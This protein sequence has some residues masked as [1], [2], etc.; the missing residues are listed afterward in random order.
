MD[1]NKKY[2]IRFINQ[3]QRHKHYEK[4]AIVQKEAFPHK[5]E[6]EEE[7]EIKASEDCLNYTFFS[8]SKDK[9]HNDNKNYNFGFIRLFRKDKSM[10]STFIVTSNSEE[11]NRIITYFVPTSTIIPEF[12]FFTYLDEGVRRAVI[13]FDSFQI[14]L[15]GKN[16]NDPNQANL[17][18]IA[19]WTTVL[20]DEFYLNR[21]FTGSSNIL[22]KIIFFLKKRSKSL[23]HQSYDDFNSS[24]NNLLIKYFSRK[25]DINL[26]KNYQDKL[27]GELKKRIENCH[28]QI[29]YLSDKSNSIESS[30]VLL[31]FNLVYYQWIWS[32]ILR[33]DQLNL[34]T[35]ES[36]KI[37]NLNLRYSELFKTLKP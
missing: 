14:L 22:D 11:S 15:I 12:I 8:I 18:E 27:K 31:I 35:I 1:L 21:T 36:N 32:A 10:I 2:I 26:L 24:I 30:I 19:E 20:D 37:Q 5:I 4:H 3:D 28:F 9:F 13:N 33:F 6:N 34:K 7:Y 17:E 25:I 16:L 23:F 29:Y